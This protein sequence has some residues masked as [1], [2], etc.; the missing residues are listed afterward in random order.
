MF[1]PSLSYGRHFGPPLPSA[2]QAAVMILLEPGNDSW[3]IPLTVRSNHLPDHPGQI[4]LPGGR[5]EA[6]ESFQQA[7]E[8]EFGEELGC[9]PF[10]GQVVGALLPLYVFHSNYY[11]QPIVAISHRRL[12]YV[13]CAREVTEVLQLPITSLSN[14]IAQPPQDFERGLVTW[15]APTITCGNARIWGATAIVL[16]E[17]LALLADPPQNLLTPP[18]WPT[19]LNNDSLTRNYLTKLGS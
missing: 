15:T 7:A 9:V 14:S 6:G 3:S 2:R 8:R 4:S 19:G 1:S 13:P 18:R 17:L 11:V 16:G 10:P 5:L 12:E